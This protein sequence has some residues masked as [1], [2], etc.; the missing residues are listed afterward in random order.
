MDLPDELVLCVLERLSTRDLSRYM[1][2]G[3]ASFELGKLA[4]TW[5][6]LRVKLTIDPPKPNARK[7]KTPYDVVIIKLC[8]ACYRRLSIHGK[9]VCKICSTAS[10]YVQLASWRTEDAMQNMQSA[11]RNLRKALAAEPEVK[12]VLAA[13]RQHLNRMMQKL[14]MDGIENPH[15]APANMY[16]RIAL[17]RGG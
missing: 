17:V 9:P 15:L 8:K 7:Y 3:K 11:D 13:E 10:D 2:T 6:R 1:M 16:G 4:I 14:C 12:L 5:E